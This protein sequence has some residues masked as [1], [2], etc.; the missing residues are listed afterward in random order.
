MEHKQWHEI[1]SAKLI[2]A[3]LSRTQA[4]SGTMGYWMASS[5]AA[6][7]MLEPVFDSIATVTRAMVVFET[8]RLGSCTFWHNFLLLSCGHV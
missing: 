1:L 5:G 3:F 2:L 4:G 8:Y 6:A 7:H